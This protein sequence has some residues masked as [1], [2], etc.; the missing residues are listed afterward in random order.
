MKDEFFEDDKLKRQILAKWPES[1]D[2][3][4]LPINIDENHWILAVV[5]KRVKTIDVYKSLR[6]KNSKE[7]K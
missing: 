3:L 5:N 1:I 2:A 7:I 6:Y 4:F